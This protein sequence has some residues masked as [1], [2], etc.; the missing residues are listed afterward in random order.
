MS[1]KPSHLLLLK[2]LYGPQESV[3][4]DMVAKAIERMSEAEQVEFSN[5]QHRV[6]NLWVELQAELEQGLN[7]MADDFPDEAD[8]RKWKVADWFTFDCAVEGH[9][10]AKLYR[11]MAMGQ[12]NLHLVWNE[13]ESRLDSK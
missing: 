11:T 4:K 1:H 8:P 2:T 9:R 7:D 5:L 12:P 10:F 13:I 6:G 3:T